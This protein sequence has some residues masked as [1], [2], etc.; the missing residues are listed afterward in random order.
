MAV[1]TG[2]SVVTSQRPMVAIAVG[3]VTVVALTHAEVVVPV[4]DGRAEVVATSVVVAAT[5]VDVPRVA[6][7]IGGKEVWASEVEIVAYSV[8]GVDAE[9]PASRVPVKGTEEIVG[10][11]EQI[12]LP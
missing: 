11:T 9:V 5:A 10:G 12:P 6:A 3:V 4:I 1:N 2:T 7:T 8:T